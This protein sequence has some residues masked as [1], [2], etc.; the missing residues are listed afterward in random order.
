[1]AKPPRKENYNRAVINSIRDHLIAREQ[2]VAVAES[3]TSGHLQAGFS[4]ASKAMQFF[5][6]GL[7]A[8]NLGQKARHFAVDP[9]HALGCNCVS[10][11]VAVSLAKGIT[12]IFCSDWG[13]GVTGYATPDPE[14]GVE[15]L[16]AIYSFCLKDKE[17]TTARID[18][19]KLDQQNVQVLYTN[20]IYQSFLDVLKKH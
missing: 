9:I 7:T 1:M 10:D 16:F 14:Q 5:Q 15:E 13:I 17:I 2:T 19:E 12:N 18:V 6:G 8:Y 4:L 20:T 3:V 11:R